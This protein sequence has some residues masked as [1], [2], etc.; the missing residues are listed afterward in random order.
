MDIQKGKEAM[1]TT[2]FQKYL[3]GTTACMKRL[4]MATKG[5]GQLTSNDTYFA[6]SRFIYVKTAEDMVDIGCNR[7]QIG[8]E[9]TQPHALCFP[10]KRG[11]I[12]RFNELRRQIVSGVEKTAN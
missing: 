11:F 8:R 7:F 10:M 2:K 3:V 9:K 12:D 6:D 1:N 5:C 4:A